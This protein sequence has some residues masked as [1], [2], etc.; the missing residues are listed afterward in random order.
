MEVQA[1]GEAEQRRA[2]SRDEE[3]LADGDLKVRL[4]ENTRSHPYSS[5]SA[6]LCLHPRLPF[7]FFL[8]SLA[9]RSESLTHSSQQTLD[10]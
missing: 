7:P 6:L 5:H 2:A 1:A 8:A 9:S 3:T 4:M 10:P